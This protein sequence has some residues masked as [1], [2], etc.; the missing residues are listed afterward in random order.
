MISFFFF[1]KNP[2]SH[3]SYITHFWLFK[4]FSKNKNLFSS[5]TLLTIDEVVS[6]S[7]LLET[8]KFTLLFERVNWMK[9]EDSDLQSN[10]ILNIVSRQRKTTS[11]WE[12]S[13][14]SVK[15]PAISVESDESELRHAPWHRDYCLYRKCLYNFIFFI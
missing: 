2:E 10:N 14:R 4:L 12:E 3:R 11:E 8:P 9:R 6:F 1:S 13:T 15:E 5:K 7:Q